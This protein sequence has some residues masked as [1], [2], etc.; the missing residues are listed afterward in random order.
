MK[1]IIRS[2]SLGLLTAA[3]IIGVTYFIDK[4]EPVQ[5]TALPSLDESIQ[6]VE[7]NGYYVFDEDLEAK[8]EAVEQELAS[9][10]MVNDQLEAA[11]QAEEEATE[12]ITISIESGMTMPEIIDL[13]NENGLISDQDEFITYL[14][15][16]EMSGYIQTGEFT[17]QSDMAVEELVTILTRQAV[18]E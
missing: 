5:T 8:I 18:E 2:F 7:N 17:L 11:A 4:P 14:E 10:Q 13:L 6:E 3:V 15:E 9:L 12:E 1:Q 16:N